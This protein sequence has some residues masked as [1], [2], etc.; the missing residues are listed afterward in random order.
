MSARNNTVEYFD[1]LK[2]LIQSQKE[3]IAT[4]KRV[5]VLKDERISDLETRLKCTDPRTALLNILHCLDENERARIIT[6]NSGNKIAFDSKLFY[7]AS[8]LKLEG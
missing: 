1:H 4:W 8:E 3:A 6:K 7:E 2:L 5:S